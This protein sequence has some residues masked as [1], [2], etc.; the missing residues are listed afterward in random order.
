MVYKFFDKKS[1]GRTVKNENTINYELTE[2]FC[3]PLIR[4]FEKKVHSSF[5]DNIWGAYLA[6]KQ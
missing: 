3:K 6:D 1:L 4:K 2:E 5:I